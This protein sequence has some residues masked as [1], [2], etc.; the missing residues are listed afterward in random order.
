M[1]YDDAIIYNVMYNMFSIASYDITLY[2]ALYSYYHYDVPSPPGECSSFRSTGISN[3]H[4]L[5]TK[6]IPTKIA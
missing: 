6:I 4:N 1:Q 3:T 2:D 5:P